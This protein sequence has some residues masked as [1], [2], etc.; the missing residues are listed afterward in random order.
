MRCIAA[1]VGLVGFGAGPTLF[2]IT[3]EERPA[4]VEGVEAL[5]D[6]QFNAA[7]DNLAALIEAADDLKPSEASRVRQIR[8][9]ALVRAGQVGPAL[10]QAADPLLEKSAL[11]R[12]WHGLALVQANRW[13][14]AS[15]ELEPL[16]GSLAADFPYPEEL[17]LNL[18]TCRHRQGD[19]DGAIALLEGVFDRSPLPQYRERAV[20]QA[21]H[22]EIERTKYEE[23]YAW[24]DRP[25]QGARTSGGHAARR[26]LD[27]VI[28]YREARFDDAES[29]SR[30]LAGEMATTTIGDR[31]IFLL[32]EIAL[33]RENPRDASRLLADLIEARPNSP[34]LDS[35]FR[36]L[37]SLEGVPRGALGNRLEGWAQDAE[38]ID[39]Q[40]LALF[41]GGVAARH[42]GA[43]D[44]ALLA[45][46]RFRDEF[47]THPS[48]R[49]PTSRRP[50]R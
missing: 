32:S 45:L 19:G 47:P 41:Y 44:T 14:E 49:Q 34:L 21:A 22:V 13:A 7:A 31:A 46:G 35:A 6:G 43:T 48:P 24:M 9:E 5:E 15:Q 37:V 3:L 28:A 36:R 40:A 33:A 1:A 2:A 8:L 23:A 26:L 17:A 10:T 50:R 38:A 18:A 39:R 25:G 12:F 27:A 20:L 29:V 42:A 30:E 16:I 11:C 4:F